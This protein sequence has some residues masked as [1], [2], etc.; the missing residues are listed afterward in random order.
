MAH[1][2]RGVLLVLLVFMLTEKH[3]QPLQEKVGEDNLAN[4]I[5]LF[6]LIILFEC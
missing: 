4:V 5:H 3:Q 2:L 6:E 1:E